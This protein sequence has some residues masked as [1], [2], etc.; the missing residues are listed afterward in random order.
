MTSLI[1]VSVSSRDASIVALYVRKIPIGR[2]TAGAIHIPW[3]AVKTP[4]IAYFSPV[5]ERIQNKIK[6]IVE[7]TAG[8][9]RPPFRIIAPKGAPMKNKR[10]HAS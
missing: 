8:S 6:K 10:K 2:R 9:P 3:K 4:S 7:I 1:H 5:I